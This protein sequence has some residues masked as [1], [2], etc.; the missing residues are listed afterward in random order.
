MTTQEIQLLREW[1]IK[2]RNYAAYRT[3]TTRA[4]KQAAKDI[5]KIDKLLTKYDFPTK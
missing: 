4:C 5:E 1:L 3:R 2:C